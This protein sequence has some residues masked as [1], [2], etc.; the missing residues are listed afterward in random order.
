MTSQI[1]SLSSFYNTDLSSFYNTDFEKDFLNKNFDNLL[2]ESNSK[3]V[4]EQLY[5]DAKNKYFEQTVKKYD[6][7][8][9][10]KKELD[11]L[12]C[13]EIYYIDIEERIRQVKNSI[14]SLLIEQELTYK[15]FLNHIK[16]LKSLG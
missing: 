11:N 3:F 4:N 5:L 15:N 13:M 8:K 7:F 10:F 2:R 16:F 14:K 1:T 12:M 6:E 9:I